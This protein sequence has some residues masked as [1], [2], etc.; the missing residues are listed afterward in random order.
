MVQLRRGEQ[1]EVLVI[2][3]PSF[4]CCFGMQQE[5]QPTRRLCDMLVIS[6]LERLLLGIYGIYSDSPL[7][8]LH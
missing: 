7:L 3:L 8:L 5:D 6:L 1:K 2:F 4:A